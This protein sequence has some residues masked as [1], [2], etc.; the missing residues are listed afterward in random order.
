LI[1]KAGEF[2][3]WNLFRAESSNVGRGLLA[4]DET[5]VPSLKLSDQPDER[6]LGRIIDLRKHGLGKEGAPECHA[7]ESTDQLIILPCLD[8]MSVAEVM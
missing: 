7:I 1:Q 8:G 6:H 3:A 2:R 4:I 5:K